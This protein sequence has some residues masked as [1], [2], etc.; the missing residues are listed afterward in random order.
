MMNGRILKRRKKAFSLQ[1]RDAGIIKNVFRWRFLTGRQTRSLS[2]FNSQKRTNDRLRALFNAGYLSRRLFISTFQKKLLYF[3]GP[4]GTEFMAAETG[5]DPL[6]AGRKR[7][8]ATKTRDSFLS[9]FLAINDF[10]FSLEMA[11]RSDPRIEI[12]A[13][14]YKP[15]LFINEEP[16]IFPDAYLLI[17]Q[18]EK[19]C[20]Y[21]L[22]IDR[23][24]ESRKRIK[25][26]IE[27]YLDYGLDGGFERQYGSKYFRL[28]IVAKT[29]ARLTTLSKIIGRVTDK[30]FCWLTTGKNV[31]PE[32]IFSQIWH[33]PNKEGAFSL[34]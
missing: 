9:H 27:T 18:Q 20:H 32:K 14:K 23:S 17:K 26:K 8:K 31:M 22:E 30:S 24:V 19:F 28:L 15:P 6:E 2:G 1:P 10:R 34:I 16:K 29:P 7:T 21:F 3:T 5:T 25:K 13:W 11:K 12:N 33:R 4:K